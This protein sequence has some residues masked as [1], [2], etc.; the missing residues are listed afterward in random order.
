METSVLPSQSRVLS[1]LELI[2]SQQ[3][4]PADLALAKGG[5]AAIVGRASRI[6]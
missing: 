6:I 4:L 1:N 5:D 2:S 3:Y